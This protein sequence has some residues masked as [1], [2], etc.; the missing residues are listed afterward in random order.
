MTTS[1]S[2]S[3]FY[4]VPGEDW[5]TNLERFSNGAEKTES[6]VKAQ[7]E[8]DKLNTKGKVLAAVACAVAVIAVGILLG[9]IINPAAYAICIVSVIC[10]GAIYYFLKQNESYK[11]DLINK[12]QETAIV[13]KSMIKAMQIL[14]NKIA[15][16]SLSKIDS[17]KFSVWK[18]AVDAS[19]KAVEELLKDKNNQVTKKYLSIK[20]FVKRIATDDSYPTEHRPM[21]EAAR[22]VIYGAHSNCYARS[23]AYHSIENTNGDTYQLL[24]HIV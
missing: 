4:L 11:T 24:E 21:R 3:N 12:K 6:E 1:S 2:T 23:K 8:Y 7:E 19:L 10:L 16:E 22:K 18:N 13:C 17:S 14:R 9:I 15:K 20:D 5:K